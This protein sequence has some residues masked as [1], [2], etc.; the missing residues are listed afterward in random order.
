[1]TADTPYLRELFT[2]FTCLISGLVK[3]Y[4]TFICNPIVNYTCEAISARP[5]LLTKSWHRLP[6]KCSSVVWCLL[7]E[8]RVLHQILEPETFH[9]SARGGLKEIFSRHRQT[10]DPWE[11]QNILTAFGRFSVVI[12][13]VITDRF[14]NPIISAWA[15]LAPSILRDIQDHDTCTVKELLNGLLGFCLLPGHAPHNLL[16]G[17]LPLFGRGPSHM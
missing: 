14:G 5:V 3:N 6:S 9:A 16:Q 12:F 8:N 17:C 10:V 11:M 7:W 2:Y 13:T 15:T 1:V 4:T